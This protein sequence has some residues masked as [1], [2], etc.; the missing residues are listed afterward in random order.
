MKCSSC[1]Y[2]MDF[3]ANYCQNCGKSLLQKQHTAYSHNIVSNSEGVIIGDKNEISISNYVLNNEELIVYYE[4][5]NQKSILPIRKISKSVITIMLL[6]AILNIASITNKFGWNIPFLNLPSFASTM[7]WLV[8]FLGLGVQFILWDLKINK[9]SIV[10]LL[11]GGLLTLDLNDNNEVIFSQYILAR[12]PTCP[13]G[14]VVVRR[15]KENEQILYIGICSKNHQH[16][17]T[18]DPETFTGT[19]LY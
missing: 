10:P 1:G 12:C 15:V 7:L 11:K 18:F 9:S 8:F 3:E 4:K 16:I 13:N 6:A 17:Y 14:Q 19:R 2:L 5:I